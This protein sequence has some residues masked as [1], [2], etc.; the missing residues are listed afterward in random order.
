MKIRIQLQN[1]GFKLKPEMHATVTLN[2]EEGDKMQ[3]IPSQAVIFDRSKNWVMVY[4]SRTK[5][6]TRP[7][8]VYRS[9]ANTTYVSGGLKPGE[10]I[11]SKNQL[12]V[13][14]ALND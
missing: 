7:V 3:A 6:E 10:A 11:I 4:H 14:D 5:I 12:L 9:L 1:V 2:F 8:E 13:Y